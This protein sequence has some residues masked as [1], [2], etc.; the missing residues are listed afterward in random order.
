MTVLNLVP[1]AAKADISAESSDGTPLAEL[2]AMVDAIEHTPSSY[3]PQVVVAAVGLACGAF[4]VILGGGPLEFVAAA[5]GAAA[6]QIVR[7]SMIKHRTNPY[8][9]TASCAAIAT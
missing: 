8:L 4:A 9:V 1:T 6:T 7:F 5:L 2:S 3:T